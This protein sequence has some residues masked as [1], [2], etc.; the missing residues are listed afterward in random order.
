MKLNQISWQLFFNN[1]KKKSPN[2]SFALN[3][4]VLFTWLNKPTPQVLKF[5]QFL[6]STRKKFLKVFTSRKETKKTSTEVIRVFAYYFATDSKRTRKSVATPS[7][8]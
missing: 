5:C 2:M 3:Y 7:I 8:G 6:F 1:D 4:T